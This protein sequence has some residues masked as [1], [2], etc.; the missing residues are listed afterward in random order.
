MDNKKIDKAAQAL[1]KKARQENVPVND[2]FYR[3]LGGDIPADKQGATSEIVLRACVILENGNKLE[4][5][6]K[7]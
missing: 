1:A 2:L 3:M 7:P 4:K 6:K 5:G